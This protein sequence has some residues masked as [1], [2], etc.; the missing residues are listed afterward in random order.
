MDWPEGHED[1]NRIVSMYYL[2]RNRKYIG[3]GLKII[4][5]NCVLVCSFQNRAEEVSMKFFF[6]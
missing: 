6:F 2:L 5:G 3:I 1:K 4:S